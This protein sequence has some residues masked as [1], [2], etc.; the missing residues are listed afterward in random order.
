MPR[1][2]TSIDTAQ[3][4]RKPSSLVHLDLARQ[5]RH[6]GGCRKN[7]LVNVPRQSFSPTREVPLRRRDRDLDAE[8]ARLRSMA[9]RAH[10]LQGVQEL[11]ATAKPSR[12]D[13]PAPTAGVR[14][15]SWPSALVPSPMSCRR[16]RCR[17]S[18]QH[19]HCRRHKNPPT[20]FREAGV[21]VRARPKSVRPSSLRGRR[22][23]SARTSSACSAT[24]A[25]DESEG[26][27]RVET[28]GQKAVGSGIQVDC[29][30]RA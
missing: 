13:T 20:G 16:A 22:N 4:I 8:A 9:A 30:A 6:A 23:L 21:V 15:P 7:V 12:L 14:N 17:L 1:S 11:G 5:F 18:R 24:R 19:E 28:M 25:L 3:V 29:K 26:D 27:L 10:D 2:V